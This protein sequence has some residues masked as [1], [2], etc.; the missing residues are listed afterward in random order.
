M[1]R[2]DL[3]LF[4]CSKSQT[5]YLLA[6]HNFFMSNAAATQARAGRHIYIFICKY[7]PNEIDRPQRSCTHLQFRALSKLRL[8]YLLAYLCQLKLPHLAA[9]CEWHRSR[10]TTLAHP[11]DVRRC[12]VLAQSLGDP[13]SHLSLGEMRRCVFGLAV[14]ERRDNLTIMVI[15]EANDHGK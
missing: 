11:E 10:Y 8:Q 15:L 6:S 5:V 1:K 13:V 9:A 4:D 2:P 3:E 7:V 12:L 14:E